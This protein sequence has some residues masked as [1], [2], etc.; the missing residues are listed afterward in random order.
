[1]IT[2]MLRTTYNFSHTRCQIATI[3]VS[4]VLFFFCMQVSVVYANPSSDFLWIKNITG[5]AWN[6]NIGWISLSCENTSNCFDGTSGVTYGI[7]VAQ[8]KP[9]YGTGPNPEIMIIDRYDGGSTAGGRGYA[10]NPSVGFITFEDAT[11]N[12][13]TNDINYWHGGS[14]I[15]HTHLDNPGDVHGF[16]Y[17]YSHTPT[18]VG[19]LRD[20]INLTNYYDRLNALPGYNGNVN[21]SVRLQ[22]GRVMGWAWT[23]LYGWISFHCEN[24]GTCAQVNYGGQYDVPCSSSIQCSQDGYAMVETNQWCITATTTC[25]V[26]DMCLPP[27]NT[28]IVDQP[29]GTLTALPTTVRTGTSTV[30]SWTASNYTQCEITS[31]SR[32]SWSWASSAPL[33]NTITTSPIEFQITYTLKCRKGASPY[34][35]LDDVSVRLIHDLKEF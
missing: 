29:S 21:Y 11:G 4:V 10:W 8:L 31:T 5:W 14:P 27:T 9:G 1:M 13:A 3:A 6:P 12:S 26:G 23:P 22:N 32:E 33:P 2:L 35:T 15:P 18:N 7:A 17:M 19:V 25:A 16:A 30:L 28:C 20:R 34:Q 24:T